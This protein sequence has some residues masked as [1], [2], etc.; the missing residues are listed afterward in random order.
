[1]TKYTMF[2]LCEFIFML[3]LRVT[4]CSIM[5]LFFLYSTTTTRSR[6]ESS[7]PR[8]RGPAI[9]GYEKVFFLAYNYFI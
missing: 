7:I 9:A 1:M 4:T 3:A 5:L 6:I 2:K 8:K